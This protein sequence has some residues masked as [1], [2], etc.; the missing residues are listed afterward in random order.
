MTIAMKD[1]KTDILNHLP[2]GRQNAVTGKQI[3]YYIGDKGTRRLRLAI[4]ALIIEDHVPVCFSASEPQGYFIA[5]TREECN[6][7]LAVLRRGY[8]MEIFRHYKHLRLARDKM[9][10]QLGMGI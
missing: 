1:Y 9:F 10:P 2:K 4:N 8:A 7:S 6:D 3:A 5:A